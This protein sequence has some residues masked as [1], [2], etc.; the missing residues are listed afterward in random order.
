MTDTQA[1]VQQWHEL[2]KSKNADGLSSILAEEVVFYSPVVFK[3]QEGKQLAT[4]Y[5]SAA[6]Y[7]L[8]NEHF[9]Y[10][11]EILNDRQAA[12]E[13]ET[14]IDGITIN[15]I[16]IITWNEA[17]KII[18]FKVMV[19]PLKGVQKIHEMM[20]KMLENFSK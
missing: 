3:A 12:L 4:L 6:Y 8:L 11:K 7:V 1:L 10:V 13:F 14:Q 5:L 17:G 19:R 15:G 9:K 18:E 2:I 20:K 16:D